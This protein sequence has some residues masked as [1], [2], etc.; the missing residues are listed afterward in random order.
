MLVN[1]IRR[2][3]PPGAARVLFLSDNDV[4]GLRAAYLLYPYNVF[5]D[6]RTGVSKV[7]VFREDKAG[8]S[9]GHGTAPDHETLRSGDYVALFLYSGLGYDFDKQLLVWHDGHTLAAELMLS[10]PNTL[11]VRVR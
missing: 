8:V 3:L 10:K 4:I 2:L 1:E 5:H 7:N 6:V 11:L 9:K